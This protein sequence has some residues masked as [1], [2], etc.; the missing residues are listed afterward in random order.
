MAYFSHNIKSIN[1][2]S[3]RH[4]RKIV[5]V[6][7]EDIGYT[8]S[9]N[10]DPKKPSLNRYTDPSLAIGFVNRFCDANVAQPHFTRG[11]EGGFPRLNRR[12][13]GL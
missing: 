13:E 10:F 9:D 5:L 1:Q 11:L 4:A 2:R 8:L 6:R 12:G 3:A 7:S